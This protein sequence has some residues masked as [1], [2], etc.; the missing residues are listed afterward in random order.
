[1]H[2]DNVGADRADTALMATFDLAPFFAPKVIQLDFYARSFSLRCRQIAGGP[3]PQ[4]RMAYSRE[5]L[6]GAVGLNGGFHTL[7][8]AEAPIER[9]FWRDDEGPPYIW[10]AAET[11]N[12]RVEFEYFPTRKRQGSQPMAGGGNRDFPAIVEIGA[13]VQ[14][15]V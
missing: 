4:M 9:L 15:G 3:V 13:T 14:P 11:A 6:L 2:N 10:V 5:A 1:M 8:A 12:V 7:F